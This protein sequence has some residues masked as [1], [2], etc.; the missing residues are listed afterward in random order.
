MALARLAARAGDDALTATVIAALQPALAPLLRLGLM[1]GRASTAALA[2]LRAFL[3]P[4]VQAVVPADFLAAL[5]AAGDD[6]DGWGRYHE[7][8]V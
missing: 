1:A 4:S 2:G 6:D 5:L 3:P 8:V 7:S